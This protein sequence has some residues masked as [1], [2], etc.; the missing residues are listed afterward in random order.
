M[1]GYNVEYITVENIDISRYDY[2]LIY[3][4]SC[5]RMC[6]VS[7]IKDMGE[8]DW[9]ECVD[10]RLFSETEEVHVFRCDGDL[11]AVRITESDKL[12]DSQYIDRCYELK[13]NTLGKHVIVRQYLKYDEDG[14]AYVAL[15]RLMEIG[16]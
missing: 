7:D 13:G 12:D 14:Q 2:A 8:L 11:R 9:D 15:S 4:Y 6:R 1:S 10:T 16:G 5:K 3:G